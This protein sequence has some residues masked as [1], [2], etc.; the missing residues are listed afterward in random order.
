MMLTEQPNAPC[1][2]D[3]SSH[4]IDSI[5]NM[6]QEEEK[7]ARKRAKQKAKMFA[8]DKTLVRGNVHRSKSPDYGYGGLF[9]G[10]VKDSPRRKSR[11]PSNSK[12]LD[13]NSTHSDRSPQDQS[14]RRQ[15]SSTSLSGQRNS[16]H[17][18]VTQG[19]NSFLS[20]S[21]H[22][23]AESSAPRK[24]RRRMSNDE[25]L[26][27]MAN[28]VAPGSSHNTDASWRGMSSHS[29][30][31]SPRKP[32]R[33]SSSYQDKKTDNLSSPRK[34][35]RPSNDDSM[36]ILDSLKGSFVTIEF[37]WPEP[38][39]VAKPSSESKTSPRKPRR[40]LSN[41]V[42]AADLE[43]FAGDS[44]HT[45]TESSVASKLRESSSILLIIG[46]ESSAASSGGGYVFEDPHRLVSPKKSPARVVKLGPALGDG[47]RLSTHFS[48]DE[49]L[50]M[51]SISDTSSLG[52][53]SF[54]LPSMRRFAL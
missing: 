34:P 8:G 46:H 44:R 3:R 37:E 29:H 41:G 27:D 17:L 18:P 12:K 54:A 45:Q 10:E 31:T 16:M 15:G 53:H 4:S 21:Q 13:S 35:K 47:L 39:N 28:L 5:S 49:D 25:T 2:M 42:D 20:Q 38:Q 26:I 6:A 43:G 9:A 52:D 23:E 51:S 24:P 19:P 32:K 14:L 1:R 7:E 22:S 11:R 48:D 36:S 50:D 33:V 30:S 40:R